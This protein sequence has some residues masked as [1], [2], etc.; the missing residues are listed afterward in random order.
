MSTNKITADINIKP[1]TAKISKHNP[2]ARPHSIVY[3]CAL[4]EQYNNRYSRLNRKN[5]YASRTEPNENAEYIDYATGRNT[6][7]KNRYQSLPM[8]MQ[9][10]ESYGHL[11]DTMVNQMDGKDLQDDDFVANKPHRNWQNLRK[12]D[13]DRATKS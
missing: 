7:A 12:P 4:K 13:V 2:N 5:F 9:S 3:D 6:K 10:M 8:V 11:H 1:S